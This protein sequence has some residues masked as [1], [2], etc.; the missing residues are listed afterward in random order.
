MDMLYC[1]SACDTVPCPA[2]LHPFVL[3]H[4][5]PNAYNPRRHNEV[6]PKVVATPELPAWKPADDED[7][8]ERLGYNMNPLQLQQVR[9]MPD[10]PQAPA[11][12]YSYMLQAAT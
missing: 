5:K 8:D 7:E 11:A 12:G 4:F 10:V 6:R 2:F 1:Y 9:S 3:L